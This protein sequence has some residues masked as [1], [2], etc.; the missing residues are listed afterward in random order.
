M[1]LALFC[2]ASP[3]ACRLEELRFR[4]K[5]P[6]SLI[7]GRGESQLKSHHTQ[8]ESDKGR[9]YPPERLPSYSLVSTFQSTIRQSR[10]MSEKS[11]IRVSA[12]CR[13][14]T[15]SLPSRVEVTAFPSLTAAAVNRIRPHKPH[16]AYQDAYP[17]HPHHCPS[18]RRGRI[19]KPHR[20]DLRASAMRVALLPDGD[21]GRGL[22]GR[23]FPVH[24]Q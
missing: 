18:G 7:S 24:L 16:G 10:Y 15:H 20:L 11:W 21:G 2:L 4:S 23:G 14:Q 9:D 8:T 17:Q 19:S 5:R 6:A 12:P 1:P 3:V 22:R 13:R